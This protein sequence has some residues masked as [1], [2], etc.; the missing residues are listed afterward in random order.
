MGLLGPYKNFSPN[1]EELLKW[2]SIVLNLLEKL[3]FLI[4][5]IKSELE[6]T[7]ILVFLE[8]LMNTVTT[9]IKLPKEKVMQATQD[10]QNLL[11]VQQASARQIASTPDR[12]L[13]FN[14]SSNPSC[15]PPLQRPSASE[16]PNPEERRIRYDSPSLKKQKTICCGGFRI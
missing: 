14:S 10:A 9:E 2:Q 8:F 13:L 7:H 5:Y 16:A 6:P 11:Q 3:G 12:N 1:K 4:N 15:S